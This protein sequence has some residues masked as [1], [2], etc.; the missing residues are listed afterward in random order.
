MKAAVL[1]PPQ[2]VRTIKVP[3]DIS[4]FRLNDD[5]TYEDAYSACASAFIEDSQTGHLQD[6]ET[7]RC[8]R[9]QFGPVIGVMHLS[10]PVVTKAIQQATMF[11][12][13]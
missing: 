1:L 9:E 7:V 6:Q 11:I 8:L 2:E 12:L 3:R 10:C 5:G 4:Y 13:G